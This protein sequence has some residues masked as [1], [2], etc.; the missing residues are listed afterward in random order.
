MTTL[1]TVV[2]IF[3]P[4]RGRHYVTLTTTVAMFFNTT[5][6]CRWISTSL[7]RAESASC[8]FDQIPSRQHQSPLLHP[9]AIET[10]LE[11]FRRVEDRTWV[12][13]RP[14]RVVSEERF[15]INWACENYIVK[16]LSC[17]SVLIR[18]YASIVI[19]FLF[20]YWIFIASLMTSALLI[21]NFNIIA[22]VLHSW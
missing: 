1:M 7:H 2:G 15:Q 9:S 13:F 16:K 22:L 21:A 4:N 3:F 10:I 14:C 17:S 11:P 6:V 18:L 20:K 8:I 19:K 5:D 12:W